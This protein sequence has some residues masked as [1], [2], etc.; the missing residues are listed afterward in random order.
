MFYDVSRNGVVYTT[1]AT[2]KR[3][4]YLDW[5]VAGLRVL[6]NPVIFKG[7]RILVQSTVPQ[8]GSAVAGETCTPTSLPEKTFVS[9]FNM[10]SGNPSQTQVFTPVSS[11]IPTA[12]L[13]IAQIN[14]GDFSRYIGDGNVRLSGPK[15]ST[16][17]KTGEGLGLRSNWREYQ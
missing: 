12:N 7:E 9:V 16:N 6:H 2:T 4:W 8:A 13:G 5:P 1:D 17:L 10:F 14:P 11:S 15:G 3:G